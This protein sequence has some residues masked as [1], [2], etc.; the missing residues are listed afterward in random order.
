[1]A[2]QQ[3][4]HLD[5]MDNETDRPAVKTFLVHSENDDDF[6]SNV[7]HRALEQ[8]MKD[9][10]LN[11]GDEI[12][13][14]V[15]H[16]EWN[17]LNIGTKLGEG[18]FSLVYNVSFRT[19]REE[20]GPLAIK[21]LRPQ[22]SDNSKRLKRGIQDMVREGYLL[23]ALRGQEHVV[24]IHGL[25]FSNE[26]NGPFLIVNRL[27]DE[28]LLHRMDTWHREES[29]IR[30]R[31]R[32]NASLFM[33]LPI[34]LQVAKGLRNMHACKIVHRDVKPDNVGFRVLDDAVT[35]F[36]LGLAQEIKQG[37]S[38]PLTSVVGSLMYMAPEIAKERPLY[39]EKVD[40][41]SFGI[42]LWEMA[43]LSR[44]YAGCN[45]RQL[46]DNVIHGGE[47]PIVLDWWPV[48]LQRLMESCWEEEPDRRPTMKQVVEI[49]EGIMDEYQMTKSPRRE[50]GF[51][52]S[53][54]PTR[55]GLS[56]RSN[57]NSPRQRGEQ[58][59]GAFRKFF[60]FG[61]KENLVLCSLSDDGGKRKS[62]SSL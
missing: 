1:M 4:F 56:L 35:L 11:Y 5:D 43:S 29:R 8:T 3:H 10:K 13:V 37:D 32:R 17:D 42:L 54:S 9:S 40:V 22:L 44:A 58:G 45:R 33:R 47:R 46:M 51:F 2:P 26:D 53:S 60:G 59:G 24:Q 15:P 14:D 50:G 49:L 19:P 7:I 25:S 12:K 18:S 39:T 41:H 31:S 55:R 48:P 23:S 38:E 16:C 36:D 21:Y 30:S 6:V 57:S 52:S 28:T 34:A 62:I 20:H 61:N 27:K